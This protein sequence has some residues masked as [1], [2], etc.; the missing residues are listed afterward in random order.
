M[1]RWGSGACCFHTRAHSNPTCRKDIFPITR[2]G[3]IDCMQTCTETD[4]YVY[5]CPT[6]TFIQMRFWIKNVLSS[7]LTGF[8]RCDVPM[9]WIKSSVEALDEELLPS[10]L[11]S[12]I[13]SLRLLFTFLLLLLTLCC[14]SIIV[15]LG[16]IFCGCWQLQL[17]FESC[18]YLESSLLSPKSGQM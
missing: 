16:D 14:Q 6:L 12:S 5:V 7:S 13:F 8:G 3:N 4:V 10:V 11:W 2:V 15:H 9:C 17:Q 1:W 18:F